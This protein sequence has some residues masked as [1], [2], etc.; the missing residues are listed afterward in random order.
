MSYGVALAMHY[1]LCEFMRILHIL[2]VYNQQ[3][4]IEHPPF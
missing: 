3:M 1:R 2:K 4:S